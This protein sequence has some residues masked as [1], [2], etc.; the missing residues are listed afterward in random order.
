[1]IRN[2]L[3]ALSVVSVLIG[4]TASVAA[5]EPI[6]LELNT[7]ENSEGRCRVSFVIENKDQAALES[8][9]LDLAVFNRD[10]ILQ[11]R[12]YADLAPLRGG[13][14]AVKSFTL[15]VGCSDVGSILIN[16]VTACAPG[17]TNACL[18]RLALSSRA[19]DV[20]F[21]K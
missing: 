17:E 11:R 4:E 19:K 10:G 14:T 13:K 16:D 6:R 9:R 3:C 5:T 15:D 8:L 18:D 2:R 1:M 12:A 7:L 21:Y 20:R